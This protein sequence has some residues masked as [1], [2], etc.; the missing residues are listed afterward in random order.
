MTSTTE[1]PAKTPRPDPF[2]EAEL[3]WELE[4]LYKD[5]AAV[6]GKRL[7]STEKRYLRG[8]LCGYSP[9]EIAGKL[10][11][12]PS[13]L[14]S[15]LSR[16]VYQYVKDLTGHEKMQHHSQIPG[17]L[18]KYKKPR[19]NLRSQL[20]SKFGEVLSIKSAT[21]T[22]EGV[23]YIQNCN[24]FID[25][26]NNIKIVSDDPDHLPLESVL[27]GEKKVEERGRSR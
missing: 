25:S 16:T 14:T 4:R 9:E 6:K 22:M 3:T 11:R 12:Q 23:F 21:I 20:E 17:W 2:A 10:Y 15:Y 1:I 8:L 7:W 24:V 18:E 19:K 27:S 26:E 5:L 13:S